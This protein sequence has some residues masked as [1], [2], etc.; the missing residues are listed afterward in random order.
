L[1]PVER[2]E[3]RPRRLSG[4]QGKKLSRV[5]RAWDERRT[6][7]DARGGEVGGGLSRF[8]KPPQQ[9]TRSS[10]SSDGARE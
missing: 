10:S 4:A 9:H 5:L 7:R 1:R 2:R 3:E 6:S 8:R